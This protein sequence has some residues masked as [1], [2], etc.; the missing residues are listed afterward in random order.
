MRRPVTFPAR[1][2]AGGPARGSPGAEPWVRRARSG[3]SGAGANRPGGGSRF[4]FGARWTRADPGRERA[5]L[6]RTGRHDGTGSRARGGKTTRVCPRVWAECDT[7][8]PTGTGRTPVWTPHVGRE[9]GTGPPARSVRSGP[10]SDV[11]QQVR[12]QEHSRRTPCRAMRGPYAVAGV[13]SFPAASRTAIL[14]SM[15]LGELPW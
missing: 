2:P 12:V 10:V 3:G 6:G 9:N 7:D 4:A 8:R 11:D 15:S 14:S 13:T 1:H 5:Q